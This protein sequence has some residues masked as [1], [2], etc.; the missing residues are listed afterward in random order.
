MP[1]PNLL[2]IFTDEQRADTLAAYGNNRIEVPNLNKL[3]DKS[4]VFERAYVSQ[5]VCTPSRSTIMTGL[6]PHT[7]GCTRNNLP[8]D[9]EIPTIAEMLPD[10]YYNAYHGKWHLGD[11]LFVQHGF[12]EWISIEDGYNR[13][14]RPDRDTSTRSDYHKWLIGHGFRPREGETF[15]RGEATRLPEEYGKPSYL[16]EQSIRFLRERAND[17]RP[18]ALYI[19]YLEPHMPFFGPRDDQHP[20][21]EVTIPPNFDNIPDETRPLRERLNYAHHFA[22]GFGEYPLRTEADWRRLIA[23]YWGLCSLVDT[24][25]GRILDVLDETG[26]AENTIIVYTSDHGDMMGSHRMLTKS[27]MLEEAQRVPL[28]IHLPGQTEQRRISTPVGQID[29]VPTLLELM[30]VDTP[31]HVEGAS[32]ADAARTGDDSNITRDVFVE[33]TPGNSNQSVAETPEKVIPDWKLAVASEDELRRRPAE[34]IRGIVTRDK[35]KFNWSTVGDHELYNLDEDPFETKNLAVEAEYGSK[36]RE[37]AERIR[38]WQV[39]TADSVDL[40]TLG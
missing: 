8:L 32:L 14:F 30:D 27:I 31:K 33:W 9:L 35:W 4:T 28:L 2:F 21:D 11:E 24:H 36:M 34:H 29:L 10:E 13:H 15:G 6:T 39:Q 12:D 22:N 18:F 40:P 5:P 38:R 7:N 25:T 19:N 16:A 37:L 3:A 1:R 23:N 26:L 17:A 20:L